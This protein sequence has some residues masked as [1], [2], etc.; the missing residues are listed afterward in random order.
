VYYAILKIFPDSHGYLYGQSLLKAFVFWVPRS[1]W[2]GKPDSISVMVGGLLAP[3]SETSLVTTIF[4]E[5]YANFGI[6]FLF[7]VP[8]SILVVKAIPAALRTDRRSGLVEFIIA[9]T[10]IRMPYS[11]IVISVF[12]ITLYINAYFLVRRIRVT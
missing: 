11:D 10:L 8:I 2:P 9:F 1:I 3:V 5:M 12:I 6:L 7:A 4:G